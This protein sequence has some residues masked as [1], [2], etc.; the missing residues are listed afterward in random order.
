MT[1]VKCALVD[2]E[3]GV[4]GCELL[5]AARDDLGARGGAEQL[6]NRAAEAVLDPHHLPP[7]TTATACEIC[8][9]KTSNR[10]IALQKE[11]LL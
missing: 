5:H 1:I 10:H 9:G 2:D 3:G 8:R 6:R 11:L 4:G 7:A